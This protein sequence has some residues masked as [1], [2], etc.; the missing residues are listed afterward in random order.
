MKELPWR[1]PKKNTLWGAWSRHVTVSLL[2]AAL[3]TVLQ[4]LLHP[5]IAGEDWL[6]LFRRDPA[7]DGLYIHTA[8]LKG[9]WTVDGLDRSS[10]ICLNRLILLRRSSLQARIASPLSG[11]PWE[12]SLRWEEGCD[13]RPYN[14]FQTELQSRSFSL[15]FSGSEKERYLFRLDPDDPDGCGLF[16]QGPEAEES[17]GECTSSCRQAIRTGSHS[18][19]IRGGVGP[20]SAWVDGSPCASGPGIPSLEELTV[21][22]STT[23]SSCVA[24]DDL[25]VKVD[26]EE[27]GRPLLLEERFDAVPFQSGVIDSLLDLDSHGGR[28]AVTWAALAA[29]LLLDLA[30]LALI[31]RSSPVQALLAA[32]VP[33]GLAILALQ[34]LLLLPFV[35]LLCGIASVWASKTLLTLLGRPSKE[36]ETGGP[37]RKSSWGLLAAA[38]MVWTVAAVESDFEPALYTAALASACLAGLAVIQLGLDSTRRGRMVFWVALSGLQGLHWL[39]FRRF[40]PFIDHETVVLASFIPVILMLGLYSGTVRMGVRRKA[41]ARLLAATLVVVGLELTVRSTPVEF[42]LDSEWRIDNRFWSLDRHTDLI[43]GDSREEVFEDS[44]GAVYP[45][46]K[47]AGVFRIVCLGSSSTR[48]DGIR[49]PKLESYPPQLR[50]LLERCSPGEVEVINAGIGGYGLTQLRIYFEQILWHLDPDLLIFYFGGN[51]DRPSDLDYYRKVESLL[52]SDPDLF[53]PDEVEAALSLRWPHPALIDAYLFAGRSR[54]FMGMK[55][56]TDRVESGGTVEIPWA[57]SNVF[58]EDSAALLV[59][60]ALR[61]QTLLLL[62]PEIM[63]KQDDHPYENIFRNLL[64]RYDSDRVRLLVIDDFDTQSNMTDGQHMT[65]HGYAELA[66]IV[67][68]HLIDSGLFPCPHR[69]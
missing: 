66:G 5:S 43:A 57:A 24:F 14:R 60:A 54:L 49:N 8:P 25:L 45:W 36:S 56:M 52:E 46:E 6:D 22:L 50:L 26:E 40:W 33:Q 59:E 11:R 58:Y 44:V 29:A 18:L 65:A 39:W 31:G 16:L 42:Y 32:S 27:T 62:I 64:Q 38:V 9:R 55:L 15:A 63:S 37:G 4:L 69:R 30:A 67:S 68:D 19:T 34:S 35:P 20:V 48:G 7:L 61:E 21:G 51:Y 17:L 10:G 47:S 1:R 23:M 41:G 2:A 12:I 3:A 13:R 28:V 53:Y